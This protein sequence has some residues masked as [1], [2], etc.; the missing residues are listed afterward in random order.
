MDLRLAH[1]EL[2]LKREGLGAAASYLNSRVPYRFTTIYR[3]D[4]N[5][6]T[7]IEMVDKLGQVDSN[8]SMTTPFNESLCRLPVLH[9]TFTTSDTAI[10]PRLR[11]LAFPGQVGSYTGVQVVRSNGEL[12][13]TLCHFDLVPMYISHIEYQFLQLAVR[14]IAKQLDVFA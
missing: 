8:Q 5:V 11:G 6:F 13:G 14:L 3:L 9:G 7:P 12:Y 1:L 4:A 2:L 10:D